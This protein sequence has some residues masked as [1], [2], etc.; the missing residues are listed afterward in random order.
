MPLIRFLEGLE[1]PDV[2][3][4]LAEDKPVER[5]LPHQPCDIIAGIILFP[6]LRRIL[7]ELPHTFPSEYI[8]GS[9]DKARLRLRRVF[10]F[11]PPRPPSRGSSFF[12]PKKKKK[13]GARRGPPPVSPFFPGP[14]GAAFA[15]T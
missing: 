10:P 6:A 2:K 8:T 13:G 15:P 4:A 11:P 7:A 5:L 1:A 3:P 9:A 12:F 14:G